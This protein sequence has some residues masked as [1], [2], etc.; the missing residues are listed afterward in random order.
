MPTRFAST[1]RPPFFASQGPATLF[2]L[3]QSRDFPY[4]AEALLGIDSDEP[5]GL[6][7]K[8]NVVKVIMKQVRA[9][10]YAL[11]GITAPSISQVVV[12]R[13]CDS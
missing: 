9:C 10:A 11:H 3:L 12:R 7:R 13:P 6:R 8:A 5:K 1:P 4:N 2:N